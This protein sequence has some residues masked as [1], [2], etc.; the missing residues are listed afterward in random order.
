M[1]S[2]KLSCVIMGG[3]GN[4]LF[5][6]FAVIALSIKLKRNFILPIKKLSG[7]KRQA[8]YWETLFKELKKYT[9]DLQVSKLKLPMY[10]ETE[11]KYNSELHKLPI[12]T[13]SLNGV[14]LYGYFQSYK[15]FE[16][17]F[18]QIVKYLKIDEHI[19]DMK[20]IMTKLY[21]NKRTI[22]LHFRLGDYKSL[23]EHYT[24]VGISYYVNSISYI[25]NISMMSSSSEYVVVYFCEDNDLVEVEIKISA[26]K[27]RFPTLVFERA[28]NSVTMSESIPLEDW[29]LLLLMSCCHHNIIANSSFSWWSA[30]LNINPGKIVCYPDKW[31]GPKL[32]L[33]NH[34]TDDM[35]PP[36]W[37]KIKW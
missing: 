25:L 31:F 27:E 34:T 26:L 32:L 28:Q 36:S 17:E 19:K 5:Q 21:E 24:P 10:K 1:F 30:Y 12:I 29:Q 37:N 8:V 6:I 4:Q 20:K 2:N 13:N 14:L 22:S 16:K 23:S 33:H 11:F 15:Y 7:D 35:C 3:L 18:Q 9:F